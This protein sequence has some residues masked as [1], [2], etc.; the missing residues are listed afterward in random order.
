MKKHS[1]NRASSSHRPALPLFLYD[2]TAATQL[3]PPAAVLP[4]QF[5]G[6]VNRT[7]SSR[8]EVALMRAVL[9]DAISCFQRTPSSNTDRTTQDAERWLF[10]DDSRWPFS[11]IN[12]CA[13]LESVF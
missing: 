9:E 10:S 12:I 13:V 11:F 7:D 6:S 1:A 8:G 3:L 5:Y 4:E 2:L